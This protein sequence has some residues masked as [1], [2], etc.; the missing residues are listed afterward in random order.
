MTPKQ[1]F[2]ICLIAVITVL[3]T[4]AFSP[5]VSA[6]SGTIVNGILTSDTV[7]T[8]AGSPYNLTGPVGVKEGVTLTIDAGVTVN[9]NTYYIIVNGTLKAQGTGSDQ[10]HFNNGY[11]N[12][13]GSGDGSIVE[14]SILTSTYSPLTIWNSAKIDHNTITGIIYLTGQSTATISNNIIKGKIVDTSKETTSII[15]N[16]ITNPAP[17]SDSYGIHAEQSSGVISGNTISNCLIGIFAYHANPTISQNTILRCDAG[18]DVASGSSPAIR[19]NYI[20]ENTEGINILS[21]N[22]TVEDNTIFNNTKGIVIGHEQNWF[23]GFYYIEA[24]PSISKN[25]IYANTAANIFLGT[26]KNFTLP[27][28]W[29]GTTNEITIAQSIHDYRSDFNLGTVTFQPILTA[30]NP[31]A[32]TPAITLAVSVAPTQAT[33]TSTAQPAASVSNPTSTAETPSA[34]PTIPELTAAITLTAIL[35][36]TATALIYRNTHQKHD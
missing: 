15:N 2:A 3:P 35:A 9:L 33:P 14:H 29:W 1:L 13:L 6:Q 17:A 26:S 23:G 19:L 31:N 20:H 32:P 10:I 4:L 30:A 16:T 27:N 36:V 12:F 8:K 11:L 18:I 24:S 21:G 34:T 5:S 7:W 28:N 22:P 25:N